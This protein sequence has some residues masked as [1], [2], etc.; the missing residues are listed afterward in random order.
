MPK[1]YIKFSSLLERFWTK[2]E[3]GEINDCWNWKAGKS[4]EYGVLNVH[5][6]EEKRATLAHRLMWELNIGEIPE[7]LEVGHMCSNGGC[8]NPKHLYLTSSKE[9]RIESNSRR[10]GKAYIFPKANP[11]SAVFEIRKKALAIQARYKLKSRAFV[12]SICDE[13]AYKIFETL[14]EISTQNG[15]HNLLPHIMG[16]GH[17]SNYVA[18][19][20]EGTSFCV[21]CEFLA[22]HRINEKIRRSLE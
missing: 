22:E 11:D 18:S 1:T 19:S 5:K 7:G 12:E 16:C 21:M 20:S 9:N 6:R 3:I 14:E 4:K 17:S 2:V 10:Y 15:I 8:V 13:K